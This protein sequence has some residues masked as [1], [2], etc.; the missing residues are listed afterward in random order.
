MAGKLS[1][2]VP[3]K[4][5]DDIQKETFANQW[6]DTS[7]AIEW[8]VNIEEKERSSLMVFDIES[9]YSSVTESIFKNAIEFAKQLTEISDYDMSLINQAQ[10]TL[11]FD[12][13]YTELKK[14]LVKILMSQW[15]V[16]IEQK[17]V[18]QWELLF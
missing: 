2:V 1:K 15:N 14:M 12:K 6:K 18:S 11:L 10:K 3:D 9:F 8:F 13:R 16:L 4:I 5:N 7:P 17:C